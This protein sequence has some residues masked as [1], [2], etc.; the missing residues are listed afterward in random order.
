M[1]CNCIPETYI[2]LLINVTPINSKN[3]SIVT[4]Y[5]IV[6]TFVQEFHIFSSPHNF[7]RKIE[8]A[9]SLSPKYP[10]IQR[11]IRSS[12]IT[13]FSNSI[14]DGASVYQTL[15]SVLCLHKIFKGCQ[16]VFQMK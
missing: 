14:W 3:T 6:L 16:L 12:E 9:N 7:P 2:V 15:N 10:N 5:F 8:V 13:Q 4:I 11:R 1:Y